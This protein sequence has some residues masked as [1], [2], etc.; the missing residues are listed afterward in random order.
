M[1]SGPCQARPPTAR[2]DRA[3]PG[4]ELVRGR[5][6]RAAGIADEH[7][8]E[9]CRRLARVAVMHPID[10]DAGAGAAGFIEPPDPRRHSAQ[11]FRF[12]ADDQ[13]GVLTADR[14]QLDHALA[15]AAVAAIDD[16]VE[17]RNDRLGCAVDQWVDPNRL[18]PHPIGIEAQHGIHGGAA[19]GGVALDDDEIARRIGPNRARL[20][21]EIFEQPGQR[22]RGDELQRD[23]G[24]PIAGFELFGAVDRAGSGCLHA[25]NKTVT[26]RLAHERNITDPQCAFEHVK[27]I[28][29]WNRPTRREAYG[30]LYARIDRVADAQNVPQ[31]G[32]RDGCDRGVLEIHF[33]G[34]AP[35]RRRAVGQRAGRRRSVVRLGLAGPRALSS[36]AGTAVAVIGFGPRSSRGADRIDRRRALRKSR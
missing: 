9:Q 31:N 5:L 4:N 21:G 27:D 8:V 16:V 33:I 14:L 10:P 35:S 25:R 7:V 17:L 2:C 19:V 34:G 6:Q 23:H 15:Q 30:G 29:S 18:A 1:L 13:N 32:F 11:I 22:R 28:F 20:G 36:R 24:D 3:A 12:P 26:T